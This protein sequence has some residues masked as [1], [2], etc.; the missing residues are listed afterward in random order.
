MSNVIATITITTLPMFSIE[1]KRLE[2]LQRRNGSS[3]QVM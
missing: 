1:F 2:N 3:P